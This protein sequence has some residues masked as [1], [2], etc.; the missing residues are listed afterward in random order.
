[1]P[2]PSPASGGEEWGKENFYSMLIEPHPSV[3]FFIRFFK[4]FSKEALSPSPGSCSS[5][6]LDDEIEMAEGLD[7]EKSGD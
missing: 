5:A 7:N 2:P 3:N 6:F 1:M 4:G